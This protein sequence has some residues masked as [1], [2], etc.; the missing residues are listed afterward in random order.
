MRS[1][2]SICFLVL[3]LSACNTS[4]QKSQNVINPTPAGVPSAQSVPASERPTHNPAHGQPYH[5]C[6]LAVGAPL[7][8]VNPAPAPVNAAPANNTPVVT[9]EAAVPAQ[10]GV[11]LNPEHGQP[12]HSCS[13]AVGAPLS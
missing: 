7:N 5:D 1:T 13:V 3:A 10:K 9:E 4:P 11:K 2:L 8:A 12:G 6:A